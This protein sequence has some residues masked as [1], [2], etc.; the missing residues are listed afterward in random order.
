M[1]RA[2]SQV[3]A[4]ALCTAISALPAVVDDAVS[5]ATF[6][7]LSED[8]GPPALVR[9]VRLASLPNA[10]AVE[11]IAT[12]PLTP[13]VRVLE[14]PPRIVID[15]PK[16]LVTAPQRITSG[17]QQ[18]RRVRVSQFEK[19]PPSVRVVLDLAAPAGYS[20]DE[21]G[22]RLL[23][24]LRPPGE[25]TAL[26]HAI[27]APVPGPDSATDGVS[28]V[29]PAIRAA[30]S[31]S[32]AADTD[33]VTVPLDH[34]GEVRLCSGTQM[35]V[36]PSQSG[37]EVMLA[38]N[39][40][41]LE[42]H[43]DSESSA[44]FLITPDFRITASGTGHFD[45]AISADLR[46]NTCVR[47][48]PGNTANAVIS[49]LMSD[50]TYELSPSEQ[51]VFHDGQLANQDMAIPSD[52]GCASGGVPVMR[53]AAPESSGTRASAAL[54]ENGEI[55]L[56]SNSADSASQLPAGANAVH[57]QIDAPLVFRASDEPPKPAQSAEAANLA[58]A[59]A[60]QPNLLKVVVLPP[61]GA[62]RDAEAQDAHRGFLGRVK[63]FIARVFR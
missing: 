36:T 49:E 59:A 20:W 32:V 52:C 22:N 51:V 56:V 40:G 30:S 38:I 11:I 18:V 1:L 27:G 35:S 43:Y 53:A 25:A 3:A 41:A 45:Y 60:G 42:A 28:P 62:A 24:R 63:S 4:L 15:L 5:P 8:Q 33:I 37:H 19:E 50:N 47:A 46:G 58:P 54:P 12:R 13:D 6:S 21:A 14:N 16:S 48:L 44:N 10:P 34:G 29:E 39:T 26:G 23:I 2:V 9:S 55:S 7:S 31:S 17:N 57:V 61:R